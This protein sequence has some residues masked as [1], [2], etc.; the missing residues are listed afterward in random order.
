MFFK[1]DALKSFGNFTG[2]HLSWSLFLKKLAGWR[3]ATLLKKEKQVFFREVSEIFKSTFFT[4][5]LQWLLLY[6]RWLLL[7]FFRK[8]IKSYFAT[9]L[10][11][12]NNFCF[13]THRLMYKKSSSFVYK[14]A[15]N[16]EVFEITPS[17]CTLW[18]W[19]LSW[20]ITWTILF[21]TPFFRY[22]WMCL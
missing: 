16:C 9:L 12:T 8:V 6:L 2:K 1:I 14:F 17:G 4:E 21:E 15:V 5:P 10:W 7:Y 19:K 18:S 20:L 13:S 11:R 22:L 3:L